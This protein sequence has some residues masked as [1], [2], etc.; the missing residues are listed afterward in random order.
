M[1]T[2][3]ANDGQISFPHIRA[4]KLDLRRQLRS[5]HDKELPECFHGS[6]LADPQKTDSAGIDLV[7]QR[8]ILL[9]FGVLNLVHSN[10]ADRSQHPMFQPKG[11]QIGNRI[12]DLVPGGAK[13]FG[14]FLPR[15]FASPMPKKM[16]VNLGRRVLPHAPRDFFDYDTA[17]LAV[18]A[19]HAIHQEDQIAPDTYEL[20]PPRRARLVVTGGGFVT[21]RANRTSSFSRPDVDQNGLPGF[22]ET[23]FA[24]NESRDRMTLVQNS[25]KAHE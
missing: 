6:F 15:Q 3:F 23:G 11:D 21:A 1:R 12:V 18:D 14:G 16:H 24:V 10:G 9:P 7:H 20:K 8:Q 25:G 22:V 5:D 19:P 4:D 13:R 2:L 17:L